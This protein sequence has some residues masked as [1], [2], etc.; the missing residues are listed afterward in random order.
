MEVRPSPGEAQHGPSRTSAG[1]RA[2]ARHR[3]RPVVVAIVR[4]PVNVTAVLLL[5]YLL[6]LHGPFGPTTVAELT[7]GLLV[8]ALLAAWQ[9]ASVLHSPYPVLRAA[10]TLSLLVP[11]F[12][13]LFAAAYQMLA[14]ADPA[15]FSQAMSRTDTL[16]FVVT[17]FSTVG[18][19]DITAV[20]ETA[21]VLVTV[22]M[23]GDLVFVGLVIRALMTA[24]RR[25]RAAGHGLEPDPPDGGTADTPPIPPAR[26]PG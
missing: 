10:E 8:V 18:F 7:A 19:G 20:S 26:R 1:Q 5:Y 11:L 12:L 9:I 23:I 14:A 16:Y 6:P 15:S 21:R 17:V 24:M 4:V 25:G 3:T 22:Q 2:A 13:V